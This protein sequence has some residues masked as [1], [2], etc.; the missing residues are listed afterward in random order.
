MR[1]MLGP[2]QREERNEG[3]K[4]KAGCNLSALEV[5]RT[6]TEE[7]KGNFDGAAKFKMQDDIQNQQEKAH[8]SKA[9]QKIHIADA[10]NTNVPALF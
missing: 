4:G 2:K 6:R 3:K 5:R 9:L 10:I 7:A 1:W 8:G